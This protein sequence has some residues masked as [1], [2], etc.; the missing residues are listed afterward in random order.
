MKKFPEE[1]QRFGQTFVEMQ[2]QRHAAD[3]DPSETYYR[4]EVMQ[5]IDATQRA[6]TD[7]KSAP[8]PDKKA[9]AI[10]VLLKTRSD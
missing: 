3:Y 8:N 2:E 10:Y 5:L 9:F 1:I 6:V 7:L 4:D